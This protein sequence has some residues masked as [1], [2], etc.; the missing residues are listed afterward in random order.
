MSSRIYVLAEPGQ[1]LAEQISDIE[2]ASL[3]KVRD[4][5]YAAARSTALHHAMDNDVAV[6][7]I[8]VGSVQLFMRS[9]WC[10]HQGKAGPEHQPHRMTAEQQHGLWL[11]LERLCAR[12]GHAYVP[13]LAWARPPGKKPPEHV[14]NPPIPLVAAYRVRSVQRLS[15]ISENLGWQLVNWGYDSFTVSDY[16]YFDLAKKPVLDEHGSQ[17]TWNQA[18]ERASTRFL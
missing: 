18:Y 1:T 17:S 3:V 10:P 16:H 5:D 11:Y 13:P 2:G 4:R 8:V 6:A 12:F 7:M 9:H 15:H 14:N